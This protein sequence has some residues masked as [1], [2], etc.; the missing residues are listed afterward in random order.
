MTSELTNWTDGD[1]LYAGSLNFNFNA[2]TA[3]VADFANIGPG[4]TFITV[5][6]TTTQVA[7]GQRYIK[8]VATGYSLVGS[9]IA[10][11]FSGYAHTHNDGALNAGGVTDYFDSAETVIPKWF[12]YGGKMVFAED[13][14]WAMPE[15][16]VLF[17]ISAPL[18]YTQVGSEYFFVGAGSDGGA[19]THTHTPVENDVAAGA[20]AARDVVAMTNEMSD[21]VEIYAIYNNSGSYTSG[22]DIIPIGGQILQLFAGGV[23]TNYSTVNLSGNSGLLRFAQ[24]TSDILSSSGSETH[25]HTVSS[26]THASNNQG[27]CW[28]GS[29]ITASDHMPQYKG[30]RIIQRDS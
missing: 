24:D 20:G 29:P 25:S 16:G 12:A 8:G 9:D 7:F 19:V 13:Q 15:Q 1:I 6:G 26:F 14:A 3:A 28:S 23:P 30:C 5:D 17:S 18:K 27:N 4:R 10:M 11:G 21:R 2:V 22:L